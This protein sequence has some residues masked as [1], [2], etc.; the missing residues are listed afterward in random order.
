MGK[1]DVSDYQ[2]AEL[3]SRATFL[4][5]AGKKL[6]LN[7]LLFPVPSTCS[8]NARAQLLLPHLRN[9]LYSTQKSIREEAPTLPTM[10]SAFGNFTLW[11]PRK[12][13]PSRLY[14][15]QFSNQRS[16]S[17]LALKCRRILTAKKY[18]TLPA[19]LE[20]FGI[21][22]NVPHHSSIR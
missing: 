3:I 2:A 7:Q 15:Q 10:Q 22:D 21:K 20:C 5:T 14:G 1:S 8:K 12:V 4:Q 9:G 6:A 17:V 16:P 19:M 11:I 18:I 13:D